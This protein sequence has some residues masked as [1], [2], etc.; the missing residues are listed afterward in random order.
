[1]NFFIKDIEV[2]QRNEDL[3]TCFNDWR[4]YDEKLLEGHLE[5]VGCRSPYHILFPTNKSICTTKEKIKES[6][7]YPNRY[8]MRKFDTPCRSL[9]KAE[10]KYFENEMESKIGGL[11][12]MQFRFKTNYKEIVQYEQID[13]KVR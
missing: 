4:Y 2:L 5:S 11:F 6:L 10:Y 7:L 13:V 12:R 8:T 9:E 1:M 3:T